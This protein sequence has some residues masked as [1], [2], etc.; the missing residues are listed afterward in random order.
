[1]LGVVFNFIEDNS[2]RHKPQGYLIMLL[3]V[4]ATLATL[5][6]INVSHLLILIIFRNFVDLLKNGIA[7]CMLPLTCVICRVF[8]SLMHQPFEKLEEVPCEESVKKCV[9]GDVS[10]V[11]FWR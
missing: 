8:N 2:A 11:I 6:M 10:H 5:D 3:S 1:M 4:T 7:T 9:T